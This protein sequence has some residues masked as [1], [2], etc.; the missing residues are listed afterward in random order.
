LNALLTTHC[1]RKPTLKD[2]SQPPGGLTTHCRRKPSLKDDFQ[3]S[4][5]GHSSFFI[6]RGEGEGVFH[7]VTS[8]F[9]GIPAIRF[10]NYSR[11]SLGFSEYVK[12]FCA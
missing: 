8:I 3:P 4:G 6:T 10:R 9:S 5:G 12:V 11:F 7:A 1:R 2:D